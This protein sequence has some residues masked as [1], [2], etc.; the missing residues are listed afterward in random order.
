MVKIINTLDDAIS[1]INSLYEADS[2][3]PTDGDEDYTVWTA[4][5]NIAINIWNMEEGV[6]W[7]ELFV[8]LDNAA[9]GDKTAAAGDYSYDCP[10]DFVFPN[11]G[12]VWIGDNTN[13]TAY[14][15]I[16]RNELQLYE[17]SSGGWC[18]FI[19]GA[20]PTLEFN[21]NCTVLAGTIRYNYY[22]YPAKMD[23]T[24]DVFDM[25][26]PMFVVYYALSELKKDEGDTTAGVIASQKLEGMKTK[27][28]M[29]TIY[30]DDSV[31]DE[32]D[33]GFDG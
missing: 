22:K 29:T 20:S 1:F 17:N 32:T 27:N 24:T 33:P 21:P 26:D 8:N 4:L 19:R 7:E 9:T 28:I 25:S 10:D 18:Y 15:V 30:Q 16:S 13:K 23:T 6:L 14:K 12:Y 3:A 5:I 2:T 11:S 31:Q